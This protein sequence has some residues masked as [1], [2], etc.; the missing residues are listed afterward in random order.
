MSGETFEVRQAVPGDIDGLLALYIQL[1]P[2]NAGPVRD[3]A[4]L[5]L[6]MADILAAP[7]M[8]LL[9]AAGGD[10]L[11]G[12]L[13]LVIVP[14][15]THGGRPWAQIENMVVE[16]SLRGTGV[17]RQ[18]L[19]DA[20]RMAWGAGCY[21]VQLQSANARVDAHRFYERLGFVPSSVGFRLY[22]A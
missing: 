9:V 4:A 20:V 5:E 11:V 18:M 21:K 7:F 16:E 3:R 17:G 15:L 19:E 2:E 12:T 6:A 10:G 13:T 22:R 1:S 14:N 8:Y